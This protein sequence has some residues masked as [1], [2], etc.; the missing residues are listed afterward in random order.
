MDVKI[1][2]TRGSLVYEKKDLVSGA[3]I[4]ISD[5]NAGTY[6]LRMKSEKGLTG[7]MIQK[8]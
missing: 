6:V 5:Q 7:K 8:L 3:M 4:D 1:Y 2:S